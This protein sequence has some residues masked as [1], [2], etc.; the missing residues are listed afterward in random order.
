MSD[1]IWNREVHIRRIVRQRLLHRIGPRFFGRAHDRMVWKAQPKRTWTILGHFTSLPEA[2]A[3]QS[4]HAGSTIHPRPGRTS[5]HGVPYVHYS[6]RTSQRTG[7][8]FREPVATWAL[9]EAARAADRAEARRWVSR[10][11]LQGGARVHRDVYHRLWR[12]A[13][14][15]AC[16]LALRGEIDR[17]DDLDPQ[18][19]R[20]GI[21]WMLW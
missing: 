21:A 15:E 4:R 10:G 8:A 3:L 1:T 7:A 13:G 18:P 14:R 5:G 17:A 6:V 12:R 11:G 19:R 20:L 2:Q 16:R 9:E